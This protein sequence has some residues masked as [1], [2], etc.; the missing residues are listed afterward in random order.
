MHKSDSSERWEA[1]VY[2]LQLLEAELNAGFDPAAQLPI[3][4]PLGRA[5]RSLEYCMM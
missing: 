4:S 2:I 3:T 1:E 5:T